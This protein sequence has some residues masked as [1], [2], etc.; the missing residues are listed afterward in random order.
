MKRMFLIFM[1]FLSVYLI[2]SLYF[3]DKFT[4]LC[5]IAYGRD[6]FIRNDN[7]GSGFF[8]ASRGGGSRLHEGIDLSGEI[9][10]PVLAARSGI[11]VAVNHSRGMGNYI[12]I[13]HP[14]NITTIYG[15]LSKI[16]IAR[17]RFV[18]QGD[19]IGAV[20]KTGNANYPNMLPH[21]HFEVR[22]NGVPQDPMQYL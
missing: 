16:Y 7:Y 11:A 19:I 3:L 10:T 1:I 21:L 12:V 15:H 2:L 5:P 18:R 9:G 20:G 8:A 6:I 13:R 22:K 17:G 4:F 14:D